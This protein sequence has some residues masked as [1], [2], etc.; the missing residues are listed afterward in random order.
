MA[1]RSSARLRDRSTTPKRVSL[2]HDAPSTTRT[3]RTVPTKLTSVE[4]NDEMP[5]AFPRSVSPGLDTTTP[6]KATPI[7][8]SEKEMH[9]QLHHQSTAKPRDEARHLGFSSMAPYTEPAKKSKIGNLQGTPTRTRDVEADVKS[10]S[11]QFTFRREHSLELSPEAKKLMYEKREEAARIR[12]QMMAD[13]EHTQSIDAALAARK[14]AKPT[15]R[16]SSAHLKQFEKMDSIANHASSFRAKQ[17]APPAAT[18]KK[19]QPVTGASLKR[20]PSKAGLDQPS[21]T[22]SR[23]NSRDAAKPLPALPG[24]QLPRST[25]V[26]DLKNASPAKRIKRTDT[27]D[28]STTR[29][30]SSHSDKALPSTPQSAK[31]PGYPDLSHLTTPT[32][33]SLA[34]A[35]SVESTKITK[36]PAP[37]F[38]PAKAPQASVQKPAAQPEQDTEYP[39]LLARSPSKAS[40]FPRFNAEK[41]TEKSA[42]PASPLLLRSPAKVSYKAVYSQAMRRPANTCAAG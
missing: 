41:H 37:S 42:Q 25:S 19:D 7:K 23:P 34:R 3:P 31:Q 5:G 27:D 1:R 14:I 22:P 12:D 39:S 11:F 38:T 32:Q 8:P 4:E 9:P 24:S 29:P 33:S 28:V 36:I 17:M 40:L 16:Y 26:K 20:S 6:T 15:G 18:P 10:P 13:G 35:A 21:S 30:A 2:S